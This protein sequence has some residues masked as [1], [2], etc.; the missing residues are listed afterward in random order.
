[1]PVKQ[2]KFHIPEDDEFDD[3][4]FMTGEYITAVANNLFATKVKWIADL[5]IVYL[6]KRKGGYGKGKAVLGKCQRPTGILKHFANYDF[7]IW[8]AADNMRDANFREL[9]VEA[10]LYHELCH[11]GHDLKGNPVVIPHDYEGFCAEI[12]EYGLWRSDLKAMDDTTRRL[13]K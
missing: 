3:V 1:M 6:W 8:L 2:P 12:M 9:Q 5:S 11:A 7:V 10:T 4:D 13:K